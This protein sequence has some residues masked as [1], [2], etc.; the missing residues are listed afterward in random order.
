MSGFAPPGSFPTGPKA[1]PDTSLALPKGAP[2]SWR[3]VLTDA[4]VVTTQGSLALGELFGT[5]PVALLVP[6]SS[7]NGLH[8]RVTISP[9]G[10]NR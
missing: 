8:P 1:W 6:R 10:K 7:Q 5:L 3:D 2:A 4:E 9:F